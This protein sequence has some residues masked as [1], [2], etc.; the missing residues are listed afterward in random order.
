MEIR[1]FKE[2]DAQAVSALIAKTLRTTNIRDYSSEFIEN[3]VK[4]LTPEYIAW[5]ASWTHFYVVCE[6]EIII[7][8]GAIGP[9]W[10]SETES[11]LFTIFV[12]PEHQGRGIGRKIVETLEQDEFALRAKRIEIPASITACAFYRKLGYDYK[13]G[14]DQVDDE[15]LYRLEKYIKG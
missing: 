13:N 12:L 8:C 10:G 11:S 1:R 5:R 7:G 15:G 9:Y 14:V 3:E 4:V 2:T 6:G